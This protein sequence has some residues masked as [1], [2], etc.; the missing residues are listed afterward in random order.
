MLEATESGIGE[1][2]I[3]RQIVRV[4]YEHLNDE[5]DV[6]QERWSDRDDEWATL[7]GE[8]SYTALEH[9][10]PENFYTGHRPSLVNAPIERYPNVAVMVYQGRPS[11]EV[12]D[13]MSNFSLVAD[14]ELM[15]KSE[16]EVHTDRRVHRTVA[17]LHRVLT[18]YENLEGY[19][20]GWDNDPS[21]GY[22]DLFP[23]SEDGGKD[24]YW[25]GCRIS[26]PFTRTNRLPD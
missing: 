21:F 19:S 22:S 14:I 11:A 1:E 23:R 18:K 4:L 13:Q 26:Y 3:Q 17:A 25:Q 9:V 24:W 2:I 7:I 6:E 20:R 10:E 15:V 16:E 5:I 12:L 8:P